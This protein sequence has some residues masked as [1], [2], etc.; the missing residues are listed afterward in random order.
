MRKHLIKFLRQEK[1]IKRQFL[2]PVLTSKKMQNAISAKTPKIA[3]Y[4]EEIAAI[5]GLA[6]AIAGGSYLVQN[7]FPER[8]KTKYTKYIAASIDS[9][10]GAIRGTIGG[11]AGAA[12]GAASAT[13]KA[14]EATLSAIR[15]KIPQLPFSENIQKAFSFSYTRAVGIIGAAAGLTAKLISKVRGS[16]QQIATAQA[17]ESENTNQRIL[18]LFND[19]EI[20]K[21][22]ETARRGQD[23]QLFRQEQQEIEHLS[24]LT[25][26]SGNLEWTAND[27]LRLNA[28][29]DAVTNSANNPF[30]D[31][32]NE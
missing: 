23:L 16:G 24:N 4:K 20:I 13:K 30:M 29:A 1:L 9:V 21:G 6:L 26:Q 25:D 10:I 8:F 27:T 7:Y 2:I 12:G 17:Q 31:L 28:F 14:A 5:A 11:A 19:P 22:I 32:E 3:A 18:N 15:A